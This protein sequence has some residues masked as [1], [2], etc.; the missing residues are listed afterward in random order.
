LPL[1]LEMLLLAFAKILLPPEHLNDFLIMQIELPLGATTQ[2]LYQ[3]LC[4]SSASLQM[5]SLYLEIFLQPHSLFPS[6]SLHPH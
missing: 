2:S 6:L 1:T 4:G 3:P 5:H